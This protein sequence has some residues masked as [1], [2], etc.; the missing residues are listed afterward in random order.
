M[1]ADITDEEIVDIGGISLFTGEDYQ[2]CETLV[3][4]I[5]S[6]EEGSV[7]SFEKWMEAIRFGNWDAMTA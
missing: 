5:C 1:A 7:V 6:T 2:I 3:Q 4:E